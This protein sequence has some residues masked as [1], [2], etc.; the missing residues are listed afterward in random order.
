L[1]EGLAQQTVVLVAVVV[2]QMALVIK[3]TPLKQVHQ[4]ALGTVMLVV[5]NRMAAVT[6]VVEVVVLEQLA[7]IPLTQLVSVGQV[8]L[9]VP[10]P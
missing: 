6:L 5:I 9:V 4:E 7:V 3:V 2:I 10:I 1:Q 8:V